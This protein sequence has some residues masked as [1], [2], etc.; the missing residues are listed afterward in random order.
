VI[1]AA[2]LIRAVHR[3][4]K[5]AERPRT[6]GRVARAANR[7]AI[8]L[9]YTITP[10][11]DKEQKPPLRRVELTVYAALLGCFLLSLANTNPTLRQMVEGLL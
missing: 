8:A 1:L 9:A 5:A 4:A 2:A 10:G 6:P 7:F 11:G 3:Q